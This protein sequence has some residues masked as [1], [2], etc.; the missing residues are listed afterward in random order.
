ME[1]L[2]AQLEALT[3]LVN[4]LVPEIN[5]MKA[6]TAQLEMTLANEID[7]NIQSVNDVT[8]EGAG[9]SGNPM[10]RPNA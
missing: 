8:L 2:K 10:G 6:Q 7:A 5:A 3:T 4:S 9:R 1:E